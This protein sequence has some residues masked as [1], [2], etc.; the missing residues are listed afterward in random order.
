[1]QPIIQRN[2]NNSYYQQTLT[3]PCNTTEQKI[4]NLNTTIRYPSQWLTMMTN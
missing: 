2:G 3:S 1:M 4:W